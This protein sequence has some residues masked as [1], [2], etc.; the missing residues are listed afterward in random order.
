MKGAI[1]SLK[2]LQFLPLSVI[3]VAVLGT[4]IPDSLASPGNNATAAAS[5]SELVTTGET[6]NVV[7]DL[8][9][10]N[11]VLVADASSNGPEASERV[12]AGMSLAIAA[13]G[14]TAAAVFLGTRKANPFKSSQGPKNTIQI[15]QTSPKLR[16][17][18]LRLLH[19]DRDTASRLLAQVK[20]Q[21][22][23]R[24]MNWAAEKV[25]YDLERDRH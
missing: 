24:S 7:A 11:A 25:I 17:Q 22:P 4:Q 21:N 16:K 10:G 20:L 18:L 3:L 19:N 9:N 13:A 23:S 15:D 8:T 6:S 2:M 1:N 5:S 14:G 12:G